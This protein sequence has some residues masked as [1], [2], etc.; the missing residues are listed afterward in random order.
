M[1]D[2][3]VYYNFCPQAFDWHMKHFSFYFFLL[4]LF[5]RKPIKAL[6]KYYSFLSLYSILYSLFISFKFLFSFLIFSRLI[7]TRISFN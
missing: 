2:G 1:S 4:R 6:N 3:V 7:L 5:L